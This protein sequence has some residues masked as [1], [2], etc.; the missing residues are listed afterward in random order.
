[1]TGGSLAQQL[2]DI[3][4]LSIWL[5]DS[6]QDDLNPELQVLVQ[7]SQPGCTV[8]QFAALVLAMQQP[9]VPLL[10]L[11]ESCCRMLMDL[12]LSNTADVGYTLCLER[13]GYLA[14][15]ICFTEAIL[16]GR[17]GVFFAMSGC[18]LQ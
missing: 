2:G 11:S 13:R 6:L 8:Q 17:E 4:M 14:N 5:Q 9:G 3:T 18:N 12:H 1:M 15:K 7:D 16:G 10:H